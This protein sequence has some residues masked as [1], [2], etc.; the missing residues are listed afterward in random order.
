MAKVK[1]RGRRA[2]KKP[3]SKET[4][5]T[6]VVN[7]SN[8]KV[9]SV[10]SKGEKSVL[11][12][13]KEV[14]SQEKGESSR[15][16]TAM[17][18][19][20]Q[21]STLSQILGVQTSRKL[22]WSAD[23]EGDLQ[24]APTVWN[25]FDPKQMKKRPTQCRRCNNYGHGSED[26]MKKMDVKISKASESD[27][28]K[29]KEADVYEW[30]VVKRGKQQENAQ[31]TGQYDSELATQDNQIPGPLRR[32]DGT[33][34]K[35]YQKGRGNRAADFQVLSALEEETIQD[36]ILG[37]ANGDKDVGPSVMGH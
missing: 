30:R 7:P 9:P 20:A 22:Y 25:K 4:K 5:L 17:G 3:E 14:V 24:K 8:L 19:G 18:I 27:V 13:A 16:R 33:H 31:T 29:K 28:Q 21:A 34:T 2:Q 6:P 35:I 37:V 10:D 11:M 36:I 12:M 1:L 32:S 23:K 26:C 15:C